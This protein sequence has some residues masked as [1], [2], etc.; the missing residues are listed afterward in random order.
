MKVEVTLKKDLPFV[1]AD[2]KGVPDLLIEDAYTFGSVGD[3]YFCY[4]MDEIKQLPEFF[5][6]KE[7]YTPEDVKEGTY[8]KYRN[9]SMGIDIIGRVC[10]IKGQVSCFS[11]DRY[12]HGS[13]LFSPESVHLAKVTPATT[14]EI[15]SALIKE[16]ERRGYKNNMHIKCLATGL[17]VQ[18][19][20]NPHCYETKEDSLYAKNYGKIYSKGIWAEIIEPEKEEKKKDAIKEAI[21]GLYKASDALKDA[22]KELVVKLEA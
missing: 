18:L 7:V 16:A 6:V 22:I 11:L 15:E 12:L 1:K 10:A 4:R 3:N 17:K 5:N 13:A 14:P 20:G 8:W 19:V 9:G 2:T 21:E